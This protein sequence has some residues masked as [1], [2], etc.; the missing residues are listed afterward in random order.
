[1]NI[2]FDSE[3]FD[4]F[5]QLRAFLLNDKDLIKKIE[6]RNI[7]LKDVNE[8]DKYSYE[9]EQKKKEYDSISYAIS[10]NYNYCRFKELERELGLFV[11]YCNRELEKLFGLNEKGCS[12]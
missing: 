8:L 2:E 12:K 9:Y 7:L 1:M 4:K 10:Q 11:I 3:L 5:K 6:L